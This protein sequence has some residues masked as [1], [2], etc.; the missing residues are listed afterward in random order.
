VS[1]NASLLTKDG[2]GFDDINAFWNLAT[3]KAALPGTAA[4]PP[5]APTVDQF[6][7]QLESPPGL[8]SSRT[9]LFLAMLEPRGALLLVNLCGFFCAKQ[10]SVEALREP[11]NSSAGQIAQVPAEEQTTTVTTTAW[12]ETMT[13]EETSAME[14]MMTKSGLETVSQGC[15]QGGPQELLA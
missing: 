14:T 5:A 7:S 6:A 10:T 12:A 4:T 2:D 3:V 15:R 13:L 11:L 1:I 9:L 8:A